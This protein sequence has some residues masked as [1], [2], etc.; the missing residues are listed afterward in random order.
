METFDAWAKT[1]AEKSAEY[2]I[3]STNE[4]SK[5]E[6]FR[7]FVKV[8]ELAKLYND[9]SHIVT[10]A[11]LNIDKP[12]KNEILVTV[13]ATE[14]QKE[15]SQNL[16]KFAKSGNGD[17][18]GREM[19]ERDK[20]AKMLIATDLAK[21]MS[22][23][24]RLINS[25]H[26]ITAGS[27][28]FSLCEKVNEYYNKYDDVKGTQ[29]IFSD[30]ATPTT[31]GLNLY[32]EIRT[33]LADEYGIPKE[34]IAFVHDYNNTDKQKAEFE[35]KL[36]AGE[37][38]IALGSTQTMGTGKNIQQRVCAAHHLDIPWTPKDYEQRNGRAE[39]QGNV[40]AK[41]HCNNKVDVFI[42]ATECSLD[43]YKFGLLSTKANFIEQVKNTAIASRSIEESNEESVTFGEFAAAI[44]GRTE[45]I[46]K[47][48]KEKELQ[49]LE[50]LQ[51]TGSEQISNAE[52]S[53]SLNKRKIELRENDVA[54]VNKDIEAYKKQ[55]PDYSK[56]DEEASINIE[57]KNLIGHTEIGKYIQE[58]VNK[59]LEND[60]YPKDLEVFRNGNFS[61]KIDAQANM[62]GV[63][64]NFMTVHSDITG[65]NYGN[66]NSSGQLTVTPEPYSKILQQSFRAMNIRV[67]GYI[68][69]INS[70]EQA[71]TKSQK[72]IND[73]YVDYSDRINVLKSDIDDLT[74]II[75]SKD[76][77]KDVSKSNE[78]VQ[79][80]KI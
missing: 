6:R 9:I 63:I 67:N 70:A 72:I 54:L 37:F 31:K 8:P 74:R 38:R 44:S 55:F 34:E 2:E 12:V 53:I 56:P 42:Y 21:K 40:V 3:T 58:R 43:A 68:N 14:E 27:K 39:R 33:M 75:E 26:D 45:L 64:K 15:F 25:D 46:D 48:K 73:G 4:I 19:S 20:I 5:R 47:I 22:I 23:D 35:K 78:Q 28:L 77:K 61:I 29:L 76:N 1:F 17:F 65:N 11:N 32:E 57:G 36:N 49:S 60:H 79:G 52:Y 7:K 30:V 66:P 41:S 50:T 18:I 13:P 62:N 69:D 71:I 10:D 59:A 16:I 24:M 51:A 80:V